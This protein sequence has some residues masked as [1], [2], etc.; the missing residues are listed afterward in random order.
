[1]RA[2]RTR[3]S[4]GLRG[5]KFLLRARLRDLLDPSERRGLSLAAS[6]SLPDSPYTAEAWDLSYTYEDRYD[7]VSGESPQGLRLYLAY[8]TEGAR[9]DAVFLGTS[10]DPDPEAAALRLGKVWTFPLDSISLPTSDRP[11]YSMED[12]SA[13]MEAAA[14]IFI[15]PGSAC[16]L[17]RL[18]FDPAASARSRALYLQSGPSSINGARPEDAVVLFSDWSRTDGSGLGRE[19]WQL[20]LLR[21]PDGGWTID[22]EGYRSLSVT[23]SPCLPL[24]L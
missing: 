3:F 10:T 7:G 22:D 15:A 9:E 16:R 23:F 5:G 14:S 24:Y 20:F 21:Q 18:W 13:A 11:A 2:P 17:E 12:V 6:C 1:M 19:G 4:T 8:P